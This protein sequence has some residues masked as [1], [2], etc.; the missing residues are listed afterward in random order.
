MQ[1]KQK[2]PKTNSRMQKRRHYQNS[3][4]QIPQTTSQVI[5]K[6][7]AVNPWKRKII[8]AMRQIC[9]KYAKQKKQSI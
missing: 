1:T 7:K 2:P 9:K 5:A 3:I 6:F 4:A 8:G